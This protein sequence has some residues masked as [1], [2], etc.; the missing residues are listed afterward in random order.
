MLRA[1]T[2]ET[3]AARPVPAPRTDRTRIRRH[4]DRAVP[5]RI[6]EFL[7]RG[8]VAHVALVD[9]GEPRLIPFLYHYEAGH[10]YLHGSPGNATLRLLRDGRSVVVAVTSLVDLIASKTAAD[11]SANYR[12]VVAYG[13]G[14]QIADVAE[15]RRVL[16]A[17][18]VRYFPG[19]GPGRDYAAASDEDLAGMELTDV[20]VDE[21]SAKMRDAGPLGPH[22]GDTDF[23]GSAFVKP[24]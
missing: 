21:A 5:E 14:R 2:D 11:H 19:R 13:R 17:M 18:T 24:A 10:I 23:P 1:M 9:G 15:K 3:S 4:A 20:E 7:L 6:E 12:S 22:D 16:E 8:G